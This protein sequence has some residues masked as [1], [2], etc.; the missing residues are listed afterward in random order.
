MI[1]WG[2]LFAAGLFEV[3][4]VYFAKVSMGLTKVVPTLF[5]LLSLFASLFC[6]SR[7][8]LILPLSSS[9]AIW[10]GIGALGAGL[11]GILFFQEPINPKKIFFLILLLVAIIGLKLNTD[12]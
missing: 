7:A 9:Y 4:W 8:V 11:I 12:A 10:V 5:M 2:L 1:A 3:L 6:F